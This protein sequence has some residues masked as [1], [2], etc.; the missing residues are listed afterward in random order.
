MSLEKE[1]Q[2]AIN[3]K[4]KSV[5]KDKNIDIVKCQSFLTLGLRIAITY[6]L[7]IY[8]IGRKIAIIF[9]YKDLYFFSFV[10]ATFM[11]AYIVYKLFKKD[12][13]NN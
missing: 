7:S 12:D 10:V 9:G 3:E 5:K 8:L 2:K 1:I 6:F 13:K 11:N 4:E